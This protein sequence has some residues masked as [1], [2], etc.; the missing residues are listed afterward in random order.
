MWKGPGLIR[1]FARSQHPGMACFVSDLVTTE[2]NTSWKCGVFLKENRSTGIDQPKQ[3]NQYNIVY[4]RIKKESS[5]IVD[6]EQCWAIQ[7]HPGS[8]QWNAF[9]KL[10][11]AWGKAS[12]WCSLISRDTLSAEA[13]LEKNSVFSCVLETNSWLGKI[14]KICGWNS[15]SRTS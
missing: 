4:S 13:K 7:T 5:M 1:W 9:V 8:S 11:S 12:R 10:Q 3:D 2:S 15:K 14:V 6:R